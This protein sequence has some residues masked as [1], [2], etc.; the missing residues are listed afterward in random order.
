MAAIQVRNFYRLKSLFGKELNLNPICI[1]K[2]FVF[3][4]FAT[5]YFL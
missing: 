1:G 4:H 5:S 2:S 3:F